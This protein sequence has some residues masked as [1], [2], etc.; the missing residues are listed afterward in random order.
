MGSLATIF[1]LDIQTN[2]NPILQMIFKRIKINK[3]RKYII[4]MMHIKQKNEKLIFSET[5]CGQMSEE[6]SVCDVIKVKEPEHEET[7]TP[8]KEDEPIEASSLP[9][10]NVE[11]IS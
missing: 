8:V 5:D 4:K 6:G 1:T 9:D 3:T 10:S 2:Q 7:T 11:Y